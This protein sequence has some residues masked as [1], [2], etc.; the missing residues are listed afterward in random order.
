MFWL[1]NWLEGVIIIRDKI[2]SAFIELAKT[3]G[4]CKITMDELAAQTGISKRTIYNYF[5]SKDEVLEAVVDKMIEEL[6]AAIDILLS[7]NKKPS[8]VFNQIPEVFL[9]ISEDILP[10]LALSDLNQYYPRFWRRIDE[11]RLAKLG[12]VIKKLLE[13]TDNQVIRDIDHRIITVAMLASLQAVA[14]PEFILNNNLTLE[15]TVHDLSKFF[16]NIFG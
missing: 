15:Y 12:M 13:N 8:E 14:N 4:L 6:G 1:G 16:K 9:R 5:R 7:K 11:F 3:R 2:I 10:P